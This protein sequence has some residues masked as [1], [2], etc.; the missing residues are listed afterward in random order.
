MVQ[1]FKSSE[2]RH[3]QTEEIGC[4]EI[5]E[6]MIEMPIVLRKEGMIEELMAELDDVRN[7]G[8]LEEM[9]DVNFRIGT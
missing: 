5:S 2:S 4:L 1:R 7:G 9:A 3:L 6:A 8:D